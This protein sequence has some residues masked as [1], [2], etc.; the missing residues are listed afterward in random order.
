MRD[1]LRAAYEPMTPL[2]RGPDAGPGSS[3]GGPSL[4]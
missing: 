4:V 3:K 1:R 2:E